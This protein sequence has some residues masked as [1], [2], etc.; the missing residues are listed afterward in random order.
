MKNYL[1]WLEVLRTHHQTFIEI[2]RLY[3]GILTFYLYGVLGDITD[4]NTSI[5]LVENVNNQAS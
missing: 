2:S 4:S 3:L 1:I 5:I